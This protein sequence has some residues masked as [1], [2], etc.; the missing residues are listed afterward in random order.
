MSGS[1]N[2]SKIFVAPDVDV[3]IRSEQDD[4]PD[5]QRV[6]DRRAPKVGLNAQLLKNRR[7]HV[8]APAVGDDIESA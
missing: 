2:T 7:H 3:D 5:P 4:I 1:E 6:G 8:G